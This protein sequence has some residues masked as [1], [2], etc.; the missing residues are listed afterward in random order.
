MPNVRPELLRRF[1]ESS[2][3]GGMAPERLY[4]GA[5]FEEYYALER[6]R[7]P[8]ISRNT[9][10]KNAPF[11]AFRALAGKWPPQPPPVAPVLRNVHLARRPAVDLRSEAI[12]PGTERL[13][14]DRIKSISGWDALSRFARLRTLLIVL[15]GA[16]APAVPPARAEVDSVE[17]L[18]CT[19]TC[20]RAGL[21]ATSARSV[22]FSVPGT[23]VNLSCLEGHRNLRELTAGASLVRGMERLA[24]WPLMVLDAG[25]VEVDDAFRTGVAA[26]S[27]SLARLAVSSRV[28]FAPDMLPDL[29]GFSQLR[30]V[31][32]STYGMAYY[33]DWIAYALARPAIDFVF[34]PIVD[35]EQDQ[36]TPLEEVYRG[37]DILRVRRRRS[38]VF[39]V[40]GDLAADLG[41]QN[42]ADLEERL[43]GIAREA[44]RQVFWSSESGTF[45][46]QA[47][48][49]ATCRW[50]I[51]EIHALIGGSRLRDRSDRG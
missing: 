41:E 27:G 13:V 26:L 40:S 24:R 4:E 34:R 37:L 16:E 47:K 50:L 30:R 19:M 31:E 45:V 7:Y 35:G 3:Q 10:A 6:V 8:R 25:L 48:D 32:V 12:D 43:Q 21:S 2:W 1:Y 28:P 44:H 33:D 38:T 29:D 22:S 46:A 15:S 9:A 11:D 17:F 14:L 42:N 20:L 36:G 5:T 39:E 23:P 18:D 51:D 49:V